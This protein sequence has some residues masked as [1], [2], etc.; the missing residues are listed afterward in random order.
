MGKREEEEEE[1]KSMCCMK[2]WVGRNTREDISR[3]E[4]KTCFRIEKK[5]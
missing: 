5:R 1:R 3:K 4:S 2:D